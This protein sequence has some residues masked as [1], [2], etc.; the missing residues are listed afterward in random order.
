MRHD[1]SVSAGGAQD[2]LQD[3]SLATVAVA[4]S[5]SG[6]LATKSI[7]VDRAYQE[8]C[9]RTAAGEAI[10]ADAYCEQFPEFK[11]SL[12]NVLRWHH[13]LEE[14]PSLLDPSTPI[15]FPKPGETFLDFHLLHRLGR[16]G[17][18]EVYLATEGRLGGRLVAVKLSRRG[19][20]EAE[21]L[22]RIQ[23]PNIVPIHSI[24][25][26]SD[27][28]LTAVCM[29]Y[30]GSAT[31]CDVLD[32]VWRSKSPPTHAR[33]ILDTIKNLPHAVETSGS[34]DESN[35]V[36]L[37]GNYVDGIRHLGA[38]LADALAYVHGRGI[39]HRDLKPSNVLMSPA[40]VPMLLDF[41]LS[42]DARQP[43]A[44][45]GGT[46]PYMAPEQLQATD[47]ESPKPAA[48]P[49]P[50]DDIFSLGVILYQLVTGEH[51]FGPIPIEID[52][53]SLRRN[54]I[55][56]QARGAV[57]ARERN[58]SVDR[59]FSDLIQRCLAVEPEKRPQ[60]AIEI[61][62]AL[63]E[64][65]APRP[66]A[67]R[68]IARNPL[69]VLAVGL[70]VMLVVG[71]VIVFAAARP[72][73]SDRL[74]QA[75]IEAASKGD[76]QSA[77]NLQTAALEADPGL[78]KALFARARAYQ[79]RGDKEDAHFH[80]S[81]IS[82]LMALRQ[83]R[84][85]AKV[86]AG[87]AYSNT[88][89]DDPRTAIPLYQKAIADG[90]ASAEIHN[91]LGYCLMKTQELAAASTSLNEAI[92]LKSGLQAAYHNRALLSL[93][94][95]HKSGLTKAQADGNRTT[96]EAAIKDASQALATGPVTAELQFDLARIYATADRIDRRYSGAVF[97]A[98]DASRRN[99][100]EPRKVV[101]DHIF[102]PYWQLERVKTLAK[103]QPERQSGPA[104][105]LVDPLGE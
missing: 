100:L 64:A 22:G 15:R 91:N 77:I 46:L 86:Q 63:S 33:I 27:T 35:R 72:P 6:A 47:P 93:M 97:D 2:D 19:S 92:R 23:H 53:P 66:R 81:A 87:L 71:A 60:T 25:D 105:R 12:H 68:W 40:G 103:I 20:A 76:Y 54:L 57:P 44:P 21:I 4:N 48:S 34:Q 69:K 9:D 83:R 99:G 8:Y 49:D 85:D 70:V 58:A 36:L 18:A 101:E 104:R 26:D 94:Q 51:P 43:A 62:T 45:F 42:A 41:N 75:G 11:S 59:A 39:C 95:V 67:Q 88:C 50:R 14:H 31:L 80:S 1:S 37:K 98:L 30:V 65:L 5:G 74:Y 7:L 16:G 89:L 73:R 102:Q 3:D 52:T 56:R 55:E 10:D 24:Q 38:R 90:F 13:V 32:A 96:M 61:R 78:E 79:Q 82:D 29:P 17:F 28:R 84:G